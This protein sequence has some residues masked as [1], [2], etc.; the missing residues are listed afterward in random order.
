MKTI[1]LIRHSEPIKDRTMPTA[2]L[3]LS[4]QGHMRARE[5]FSLDFFRSVEAVYTSPYRRAYSTAEKLRER[6]HVDVRLR[7]RELGNPDTLNAAFWKRQYE[8][9]DYKNVDGESLNDTKE[10]MTAAIDEIVSTMQD[11]ETVAIVSHA[12]AIC[13]FLL[14][15]CTIE[16][17]DEQKKLRKITYQ[18]S[19][20]MN[21]VIATPSA[22]VL[23][24]ENEQLCRIKYIDQENHGDFFA[25]NK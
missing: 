10:R 13:A 9:H 17:I 1:I 8:D 6:L 23:Q 7:E 5:L 16:V 21:G 4:E 24:F 11:G 14:N 12:A 3:P 22:F 2:E 18:G 15:W 25:M 20:V 19:G